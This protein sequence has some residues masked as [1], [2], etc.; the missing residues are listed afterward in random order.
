ML[1]Q[2][3]GRANAAD[4]VA[5]RLDVRRERDM[6]QQ[7]RL[8]LIQALQGARA[9]SALM[10]RPQHGLCGVC[11]RCVQAGDAR[12]VDE[13]VQAA[14]PAA[15]GLAVV[16]VAAASHRRRWPRLGHAQLHGG[17][18][19]AQRKC[20][21]AAHTHPS[22]GAPV[23]LAGLSAVSA[24]HCVVNYVTRTV[25]RAAG[26]CHVISDVSSRKNPC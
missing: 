22:A 16:L 10:P 9:Q 21:A 11:V 17:G 24:R 20:S 26:L 12:V 6:Q 4:R 8:A 14:R 23:S 2:M 25:W 7:L 13:L 3:R 19:R 15:L 1:R 5:P 18:R